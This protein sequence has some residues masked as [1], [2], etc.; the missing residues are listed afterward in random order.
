MS[1]SKFS[2]LVVLAAAG[3]T[4]SACASAASGPGTTPPA[5]SQ[6]AFSATATPIGSPDQSALAGQSVSGILV[7]P[8]VPNYLPAVVQLSVPSSDVLWVLLEN[9]YLYRSTDRGTSW[10]QQPVPP[11]NFPHPEISF[12]DDHNGWM[13]TGG[14]PETQCNGAGTSV[15]RTSDSGTTWRLVASVTEGAPAFRQC[16]Q[17]LS[18]IDTTHG[19]LAASD[20]NSPPTIYRTADGGQTW[21][22]STL[23]DPPGFTTQPGGFVLHAGLV[24]AFGNS[25][26]VP[27]AGMQMGAQA[28]VEYV[29]R[30]V[31][32]GATWGYLVTVGSGPV[33]VT[34]VTLSRWLK[35]SNDGT[36]METTDGGKTW[37]S[38]PNGYQS[39]AGVA[40]T[41][42][43]GDPLL[44]YGTVRG[45]I[46]RTVDGGLHWT[47]IKT[48][49]VY[50]P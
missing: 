4:A 15:W 20:P 3:L 43:F 39:A 41:F 1:W 6:K 5:A 38:Y 42:V 8:P 46:S 23:P 10:Q 16:K 33:G 21:A 22:G 36:G 35:L 45:G 24:R 30:S 44:G 34:F 7:P 11:G 29:F 32:G 50:E 14:V 18:F 17:G 2:A 27:A 31:D 37:H 40:S 13:A 49:G 48:P 12:V 19:F 47:F 26:L 25:L 9:Q 28:E